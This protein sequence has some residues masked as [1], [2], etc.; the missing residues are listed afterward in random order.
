MDDCSVLSAGR[1]AGYA[2][3]SPAG[4]GLAR[5]A[6]QRGDVGLGNWPLSLSGFDREWRTVRGETWE[7]L[8]TSQSG[9]GGPRSQEGALGATC[10]DGHS[11]G[12]LKGG[13]W[14]NLLGASQEVAVSTQRED[15]AVDSDSWV[16][17]DPYWPWRLPRE[18]LVAV[19][20][21][22]RGAEYGDCPPSRLQLRKR[23]NPLSERF[24][25]LR[26]RLFERALGAD[27]G[28]GRLPRIGRI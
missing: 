6:T 16:A 4:R 2:G 8:R 5:P 19:T 7:V 11:V 21:P 1:Q 22:P 13:F 26:Q 28:A 27:G 17:L 25:V 23:E 15:L 20:R 18:C 12:C 3:L 14:D 9:P 10:P 24:T